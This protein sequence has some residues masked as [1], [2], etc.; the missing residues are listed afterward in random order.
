MPAI[1]LQRIH[2]PRLPPRLRS[3]PERIDA[4]PGRRAPTPVSWSRLRR[5]VSAAADRCSAG[6]VVVEPGISVVV[7]ER[8]DEGVGEGPVHTDAVE[9]LLAGNSA[10][11]GRA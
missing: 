2:W 11:A 8:C 7:V 1:A 9:L 3:G 10:L 4:H 5:A 6:H